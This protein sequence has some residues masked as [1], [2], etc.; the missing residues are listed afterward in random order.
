MGCLLMIM[1][2]YYGICGCVPIHP[3][4]R[5]FILAPFFYQLYFGS[6][7]TVLNAYACVPVLDDAGRPVVDAPG[8]RE[9]LISVGQTG[10]SEGQDGGVDAAQQEAV[11]KIV[12]WLMA[13]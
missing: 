13:N 5:P 9:F 11:T 7:Q 8:A 6:Y 4:A 2:V 3:P 12:A 1:V 10:G